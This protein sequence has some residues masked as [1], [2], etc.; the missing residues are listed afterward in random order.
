MTTTGFREADLYRPIKVLLEG[1]GYE[2]K[3]E[4]GAADVVAIRGQ[5]EPI[6][7]ELKSGFSLALFH[8]AIERQRITDSVYLAVPLGGSGAFAKSLKN[9][10]VLCR[11]LGLGLM[12]VRLRDDFVQIHC[13]PA[14]Y[15]PRQS[16]QKKA[17]LLREFARRVGDPNTGGTTRTGLMTAYRQDA[18]R[19]VNVLRALGPTKA[20]KVAKMANVEKARRLMADDHYGWFERTE[21][22]IYALSPKGEE[23]FVEYANEIQKLSAPTKET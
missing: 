14:P 13:D 8:Q 3:G 7:V 4:I 9:N 15:R 22:G 10:K 18:L 11:R 17:R 21:T 23:A 16:A 12:T 1:Q 19:C 20:A 6:V 2:V 5:E